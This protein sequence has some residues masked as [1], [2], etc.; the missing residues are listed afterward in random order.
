MEFV[1]YCILFILAMWGATDLAYS[2][3]CVISRKWGEDKP[4]HVKRD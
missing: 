2:L 4:D 1:G 3:R